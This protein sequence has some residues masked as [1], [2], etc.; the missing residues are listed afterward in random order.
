M[1]SELVKGIIQL[2]PS[3]PPLIP[4]PPF[5]NDAAFAFGLTDLAIGYEPATGKDAENMETTIEPV[6]DADHNDYIMQKSPAEQLT[7][8]GK[9]PELFVTGEALCHAP[10]DRCAVRLLEQAGMDIEHADLGKE[11]I[12]F[13]GYMSFM[14]RSNLQIADRVCQWIQQH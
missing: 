7:N 8:L 6:T 11:Y 9:I 12:H 1:R 10:Y 2:E 3:D 4:R 13:N 5:G 14:E